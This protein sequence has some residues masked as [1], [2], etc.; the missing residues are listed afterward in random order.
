MDYKKIMQDLHG[1][2]SK[3]NSKDISDAVKN[4]GFETVKQW[5]NKT[6]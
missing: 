3:F 4:N 6:I 2:L 1:N 5:L